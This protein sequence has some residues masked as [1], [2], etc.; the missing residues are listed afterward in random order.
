M[1]PRGA[2]HARFD[3]KWWCRHRLRHSLSRK[4]RLSVEHSAA[5]R[6]VGHFSAAEETNA[7]RLSKRSEMVVSVGRATALPESLGFDEKLE[8]LLLSMTHDSV[9]APCVRAH[10]TPYAKQ[11]VQRLFECGAS[12]R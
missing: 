7:G 12:F 1:L 11:V 4:L 2:A 5:V 3:L 6:L 8:D 10:V 9:L